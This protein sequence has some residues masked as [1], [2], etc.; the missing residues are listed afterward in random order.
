MRI[1]NFELFSVRY[2]RCFL[3]W[4][5]IEETVDDEGCRAYRN[6]ICCK[7]EVQTL[8]TKVA[9]LLVVGEARHSVTALYSGNLR[10][11]GKVRVSDVRSGLFSYTT[12]DMLPTH[13]DCAWLRGARAVT[14]SL[15]YCHVCANSATFSSH[16]MN[17]TLREVLL[18]SL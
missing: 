11:T 18:R 3:T 13:V 16:E 5:C 14:K 9:R 2:F 6:N 12:V 1:W 8:V 4:S 7:K 10:H 15:Q 17:Q